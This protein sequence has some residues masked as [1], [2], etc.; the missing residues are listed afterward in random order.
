MTSAQHNHIVRLMQGF[1]ADRPNQTVADWC[2]QNVQF[3]EP[4]NHGPFSLAGREYAREILD[5]FADPK[6]TDLVPVCGSQVGKTAIVMGGSAWTIR[7][8]PTRIFW[9]MPTRDTARGFSRTRWMPM[10]RKS[11]Q[12]E[13]LIPTGQRRHDFASLQQDIGGSHIDFVWSNSPSALASVPARVVVL[14][15]VDKFNEGGNGEADAVNLADQRT[16]GQSMPK[17]IKTS[18]PTIP[19]GLIWQEFLKTDQR[20]RFVPCPHCG[21]FVVFAWS[22]SYTMLPKT[23]AEA[24]VVWDQEAKRA[25]G[26]WDLDRVRETAHYE[27]P[28]CKGKIN[29]AHKTLIDRRGEWR[30]TAKA[31]AGYRGWHLPSL[32]SCHS[33]CNVGRLAVKFLQAKNSLL[34][35]QGFINGDLAEPYM[36][37]D[38]LGKRVELIRSTIEIT[39]EATTLLTVDVQAKGPN[40]FWFVARRWASAGS[41]GID[42]GGLETWEDVRK[43]QEALKIKDACVMVDSG[44]GAKDDAAVYRQCAQFG[45]LKRGDGDRM[46]HIGWMPAKGM[47]G[48]KRWKDQ[49]GLMSP[50]KLRSHD[51]FQGSDVAGR[52]TQDLFEFSSDHFNDILEGLRVR[53]GT[54]PWSVSTAM[55]TQEY[56]RHIDGEIL[57][58]VRNKTSGITVQR[59]EPRHRHWPNHMRDCEKMQVAFATFL[60]LFSY[61]EKT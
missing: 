18:T 27:C 56:W 31:A 22:Q 57:I 54:Y 21:G 4:N 49:D 3:D 24:Y 32:Y 13:E 9:V 42:A 25:D 12:L 7:H 52:V 1:F 48:R 34:G 14:D 44:Y 58:T 55:A 10:I 50:Y 53:R 23:G 35:L 59:W 19:E 11:P 51:P 43:K 33:E 29:D 26:S 45:E 46:I 28:H 2:V 16:K 20:R 5:A 39:S 60:G 47:P 8:D 41:D 17:R 38:T 40:F 30:P 61:E 37:Q 6:V 36:S 15:E